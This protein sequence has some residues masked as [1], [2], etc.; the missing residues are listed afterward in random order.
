MAAINKRAINKLLMKIVRIGRLQNCISVNV[1]IFET[2]PLLTSFR[3]FG[4]FDAKTDYIVFSLGEEQ[5]R[6]SGCYLFSGDRN[7]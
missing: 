3:S 4:F 5:W 1:E 7:I 2:N 6:E